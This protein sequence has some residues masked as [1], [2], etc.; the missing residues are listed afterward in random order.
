MAHLIRR[1]LM[2]FCSMVREALGWRRE[3]LECSLK[4]FLL[5]LP[6]GTIDSF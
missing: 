2:R 5:L 4:E 1:R 6:L 3:V